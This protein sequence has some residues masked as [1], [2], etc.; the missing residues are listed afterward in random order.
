MPKRLSIRHRTL[1]RYDGEVAHSAQY[2]R[3]TPLTNARQR[4]LTWRIDAPGRLH[5]WTDA[6]GNACHT[7]VLE[8]PASTLEIVASGRVET[9]DTSGITPPD[10]DSLAPEVYLRATPLTEATAP[11]RDF[12]ERLRG[13]ME[14]NR[15]AG[16]HGLMNAV[17]AAVAYRVGETRVD[18][19]AAAALAAGSGVCQDH[20]HLFIACARHL[21]VPARY[22]SGYMHT[23]DAEGPH[24]AS[25]AWA[26]A[27]VDAL[28]WVS[29][30]PANGI[31]ATESY[32]AIA[33]ALDYHGASPVR[34]VRRG[35]AG[36]TLSVSV[37]I[38]QVQQ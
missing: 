15:I 26:E 33:A 7:L 17:G 8:R 38:D 1:Y 3:L 12:A 31:S 11:V 10:E 23:E 9:T 14:A 30:D 20:A 28:G 37:N 19:T 36:E 32:V 4:V 13:D 2:L 27:W 34:G 6:F 35:G 29:F 25:H 18:T 21:G 22:V 16:L 24:E 5:E